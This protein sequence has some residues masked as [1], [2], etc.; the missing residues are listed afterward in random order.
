M[1]VVCYITVYKSTRHGSFILK[2]NSNNYY[3][4]RSLLCLFSCGLLFYDVPGC[5][6]LLKRYTGVT[7]IPANL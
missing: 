6:V 3:K 7:I 2:H 4:I 5:S 1:R